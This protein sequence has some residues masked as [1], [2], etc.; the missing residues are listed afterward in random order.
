LSLAE[1]MIEFLAA[2]ALVGCIAVA[3]VWRHFFGPGDSS[4]FGYGS[5]TDLD[6]DGDGGGGDGGD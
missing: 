5:S 4:R 1:P 6:C 3:L 2:A